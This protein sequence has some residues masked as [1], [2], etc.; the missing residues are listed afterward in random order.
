MN[1]SIVSMLPQAKIE[2]TTP[3]LISL[4]HGCEL[5][6]NAIFEIQ[7]PSG[8]SFP[9]SPCFNQSWICLNVTPSLIR[10]KSSGMPNNQSSDLIFSMINPAAAIDLNT[11][12]FLIDVKENDTMEVLDATISFGFNLIPGVSLLS[13]TPSSKDVNATEVYYQINLTNVHNLSSQN[14]ICIMMPLGLDISHAQLEGFLIDDQIIP[15]AFITVNGNQLLINNAL[16]TLNGTH[17]FS[18][19]ISG[20][21]NPPMRSSYPFNASFTLN[22]SPVDVGVANV[23]YGARDS[24]PVILTTSTSITNGEAT[25]IS[26][27]VARSTGLP[28]DNQT[29]YPYKLYLIY[30][31]DI[32]FCNCFS[33]TP[34][35]SYGS[36]SYSLSDQDFGVD[37]HICHANLS[38]TTLEESI[39]FTITCINPATTQPTSPFNV[40][41]K[42]INDTDIVSG[43]F[44]YF[45]QFGEWLSASQISKQPNYP[46]VL[47]QACTTLNR[48]SNYPISGIQVIPD[49]AVLPPKINVSLYCSAFTT[50]VN[51]SCY[52]PNCSQ[53]INELPVTCSLNTPNIQMQLDARGNTDSNISICFTLLNPLISSTPLANT[54]ILTIGVNNFMVDDNANISMDAALCDYPCQTCNLGNPTS[55]LSCFTDGSS[56]FNLWDSYANQ[57]T[58]SCPIGRYSVPTNPLTC[59]KC[60]SNCLKCSQSSTNCTD[61]PAGTVLFFGRCINVCPVGFYSSIITGVQAPVCNNCSA[62]CL[63]CAQGPGF[64]TSCPSN[65]ILSD[66]SC[67][68]SCSASQFIG[69]DSKN[70]SRCLDCS[71]MCK[72]CSGSSTNCTTCDVTSPNKKAL[73]NGMCVANCPSGYFPNPSNGICI[74]CVDPCNQCSGAAS[75]CTSCSGSTPYLQKDKSTCVANCPA[76]YILAS[77]WCV[78]S[79]IQNTTNNTVPKNSVSVTVSGNSEQLS[80]ASVVTITASAVLLGSDGSA[81]SGYSANSFN[82]SFVQTS[83]NAIDKSVM[84]I[85]GR[86]ISINAFSLNYNVEYAFTVKACLS[87]NLLLCG[88]NSF[89]FAVAMRQ[90]VAK[91]DGTDKTIGASQPLT[92]N[93]SNSLDCIHNC[94]ISFSR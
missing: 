86:T 43:T 72:G 11:S 7:A 68:Q 49:P 37:S 44:V 10:I 14:M 29:M 66:T 9:D 47:T 76:G 51:N 13:I 90:P 17:Y 69:I 56:T 36:V 5:S 41:I 22:Q 94:L 1:A 77:G 40:T 75:T 88:S 58:N 78:L 4:W 35:T 21:N 60:D 30:P 81:T 59:L 93:G 2:E 28:P 92:L 15:T 48:L 39:G 16:Q 23:L 57:C 33:L 12:T 64:C 26:F 45:T 63:T 70:N 20:I 82:Y 25:D 31:G 19:V 53:I 3:Y 54:R 8:F 61:C 79:P 83:A 42:D 27:I 18:I 24:E 46:G 34:D 84:N 73:Y 55:C 91:I 67:V 32:S 74:K 50:F 89:T 65:T 62:N 52:G 71:S 85:I 87:N 80:R 6:V 38:F